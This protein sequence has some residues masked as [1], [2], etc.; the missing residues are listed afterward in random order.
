MV[1]NST[2]RAGG[3]I[4][5][6]PRHGLD[7]GGDVGVVRALDLDQQRGDV[8]AEAAQKIRHSGL[9]GDRRKTGPI[10]KLD[11]SDRLRFHPRHRPAGL[12]QGI[13][14]QQRAGLMPMVRHRAIGDLGD[15]PERALR[16]DHQVLQ[17]LEG[18]VEID[19][20]VEGV[21]GRILDRELAPDARRQLS[22]RAHLVP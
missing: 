21:S 1:E 11:G 12:D 22:V 13:E 4:G 10:D 19:Q 9:S 17:D 7:L 16:T 6:G 15:E 8:R 2:G 18:I 3:V 5:E 14:K 20:C